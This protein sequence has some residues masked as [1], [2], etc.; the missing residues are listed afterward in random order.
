MRRWDQI[1]GKETQLSVKA[2]RCILAKIVA[3]SMVICI[4]DDA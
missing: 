2:D 4:L 1:A 3:A